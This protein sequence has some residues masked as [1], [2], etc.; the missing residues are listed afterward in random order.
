[1]FVRRRRRAPPGPHDDWRHVAPG[2]QHILGASER[3]CPQRVRYCFESP[4]RDSAAE[5]AFN[6]RTAGKRRTPPSD[7]AFNVA[8]VSGFDLKRI[9]SPKMP[10]LSH[11]IAS[12]QRFD[13]SET[14]MEH[15][16]CPKHP[17]KRGVVCGKR[18]VFSLGTRRN[19]ER[20]AR[21]CPRALRRPLP[22][23]AAPRASVW[24]QGRMR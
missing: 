17:A 2:G 11:E 23:R 20:S 15:R 16:P 12:R 9:K 21:G 19:P 13:R 10:S 5:V 6:T 24:T 7:G 22:P 8:C 14:F 4:C 1:M 3:S 18:N